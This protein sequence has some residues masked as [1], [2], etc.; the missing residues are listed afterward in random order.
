MRW[1][2]CA[3][4]RVL[5]RDKTFRM[6]VHKRN[7]ESTHWWRAS[8]GSGTQLLAFTQKKNVYER[9]RS[10]KMFRKPYIYIYNDDDSNDRN[11]VAVHATLQTHEREHSICCKSLYLSQPYGRRSPFFGRRCVHFHALYSRATM[12]TFNCNIHLFYSCFMW[13]SCISMLII[14]IIHILGFVWS[15]TT[16]ATTTADT[17]CVSML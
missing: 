17:H 3:V 8:L 14:I 2:V 5:T 10:T 11:G 15:T 1:C 9:V 13:H 7:N 16:T 4:R 12:W 6:F